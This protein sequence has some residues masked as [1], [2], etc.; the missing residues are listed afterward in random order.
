MGESS[1]GS[2]SGP[3]NANELDAEYGEIPDIPDDCD[4]WE[5]LA[6]EAIRAAEAS[7]AAAAPQETEHV[8][9]APEGGT[10]TPSVATP[11]A[12]LPPVADPPRAL[13]PSSS[14][15]IYALAAVVVLNLTLMLFL[16]VKGD[17]A[18]PTVVVAE[19]ALPRGA[20][21]EAPAVI[22]APP[23]APVDP[24]TLARE[25]LG[26]GYLTEAVTILESLLETSEGL[27]TSQKINLYLMLSRTYRELGEIDKA[28]RYAQL[29]TG[30]ITGDST[31]DE[32][33]A[34][35][36]AFHAQGE[37]ARA[38]RLFY[39]FLARCDALEALEANLE[40]RAMIEIGDTFR[41]EALGAAPVAQSI[42]SAT[43]KEPP[44]SK[45]DGP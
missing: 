45:E 31:P 2:G 35:A 33:L 18:P 20:A 44:A 1:S 23:V 4:E 17:R 25:K 13:L 34:K 41:D 11:P 12:A 26:E 5:A 38:R 22:E 9:G 21:N 14:W 6:A 32:L 16:L 28:S 36:E 39:A 29:A 24:L 37:H 27:P 8:E 3:L 40:T 30:E 15:I 42:T 7:T 10:A 43:A 19:P